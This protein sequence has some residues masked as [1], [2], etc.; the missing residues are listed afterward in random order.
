[1]NIL[2]EAISWIILIITVC[3]L[4]LSIK[5]NKYCWIVYFIADVSWIAINLFYG[6]Y[7]QATMN[8]IFTIV[9]V[10]GWLEWRKDDAEKTKEDNNV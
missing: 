4:F 6:L 9:C 10:Y 8:V 3:A 2:I 1:M 7:A 5:K